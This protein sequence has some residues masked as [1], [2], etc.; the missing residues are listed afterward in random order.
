MDQLSEHEGR[1]GQELRTSP[2]A[3][4][5]SSFDDLAKGLASGTL[6]R[7]GALRLLGGALVGGALASLPG[8]A[9]ASGGGNSACA[10]FCNRVFAPGPQRGRCK[11]QGARGRGPCYSCTPGLG[12]GP[13][14]TPQCSPNEEFDPE[15]CECEATTCIPGSCDNGFTTCDPVGCLCFEKQGGGGACVNN[16]FCSCPCSSDA[17]CP[18]GFSCYVNTNCGICGAEG[19]CGPSTCTEGGPVEPPC[20][21]FIMTPGRQTAAGS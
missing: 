6:S 13:H 10:R 4:D 11:S 2:T 3:T 8:M 16:F 14:F 17:D 21:Q 15:T 7:G 12:P 20:G 19:Y 9:W 5:A 18:S 1:Y